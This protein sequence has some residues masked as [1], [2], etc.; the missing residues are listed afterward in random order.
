M[1]AGVLT[2]F[3]LFAQ[4]N[5]CGAIRHIHLFEVQNQA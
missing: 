4:I 5:E 2:Y 1:I 3:K